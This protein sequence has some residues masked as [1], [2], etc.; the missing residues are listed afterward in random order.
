MSNE[1]TEYNEIPP[2]SN[3][4]VEADGVYV[5]ER[6]LEEHLHRGQH[7]PMDPQLGVTEWQMSAL[8]HDNNHH[9]GETD[10]RLYPK[11]DKDKEHKITHPRANHRQGKK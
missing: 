10:P 5:N 4:V 3:D 7:F 11:K 8:L 2:L 1:E 9:E 6:G